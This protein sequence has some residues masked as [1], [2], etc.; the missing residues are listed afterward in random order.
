MSVLRSLSAGI[1]RKLNS[2][3]SSASPY[4]WDPSEFPT[5]REL[6]S[7][8]SALFLP[9]D[10][11]LL[12]ASNLPLNFAHRCPRQMPIKGA[13]ATTTNAKISAHCISTSPL[14][15]QSLYQA[16]PLTGLDLKP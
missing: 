14:L 7:T 12:W 6:T 8:A 13:T 2:D 3:D 5:E 9:G 1:R 10:A 16:S 4:H 11:D 15:L